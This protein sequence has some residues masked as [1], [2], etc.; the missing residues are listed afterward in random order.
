[1]NSVHEEDQKNHEAT[2]IPELR[3]N[4]DMPGKFM[5]FRRTLVEDA[6]NSLVRN[7]R[8]TGKASHRKIREG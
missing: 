2:G 8:L 4:E 7:F 6:C 5:V 3:R 1:M